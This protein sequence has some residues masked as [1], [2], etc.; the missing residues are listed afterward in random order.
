[1]E[2]GSETAD[3]FAGSRVEAGRAVSDV[4]PAPAGTG[5]GSSGSTWAATG[6]R[7]AER[8]AAGSGDASATGGR[9]ESG[10]SR[11]PRDPN[12]VYSGP[13]LP[14]GAADWNPATDGENSR[15]PTDRGFART[16][17]APADDFD[18]DELNEVF[19]PD[20]ARQR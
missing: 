14:A 17:G 2:I 6:G 4:A 18:L 9:Y 12:R 10:G 11:V 13:V 7:A 1:V 8:A 19:R 16:E 20:P 15:L 5:A 3:Q